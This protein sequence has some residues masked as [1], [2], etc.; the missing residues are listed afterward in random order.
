MIVD[1][2]VVAPVEG[3]P[4]LTEEAV[5]VSDDRATAARALARAA[6]RWA[7]VTEE[8]RELMP[9]SPAALS[10]QTWTPGYVSDVLDT[11]DGPVLYVDA[12]GYVS[13]AMAEALT[14]IVRNELARA[15]VRSA[16]IAN[17]GRLP[18]DETVLIATS[19]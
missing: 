6:H 1:D 7:H 2:D 15:G 11:P 9:G 14:G 4:G 12:E 8:G 17:G 19:P 13:P 16:R 10:G 3:D 18:G 5:V